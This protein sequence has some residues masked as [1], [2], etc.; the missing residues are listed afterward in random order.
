MLITAAQRKTIDADV[1]SLTRPGVGIADIRVFIA[2]S[3]NEDEPGALVYSAS[4]GGLKADNS[5][6]SF[7]S[8]TVRPDGSVLEG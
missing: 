1:A 4:H 5:D 3:Y 6:W 8:A 2:V 7:V